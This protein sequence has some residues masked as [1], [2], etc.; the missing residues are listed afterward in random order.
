MCQ[1]QVVDN[2][3]GIPLDKQSYLFNKFYRIPTGNR[4]NVKG[5][6]LGLYYVK[7]M[8]EFHKGNIRLESTPGKGSTFTLNIPMK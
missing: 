6:G 7:M 3:I 1:I 4:H 5:Y 8:A 2:G